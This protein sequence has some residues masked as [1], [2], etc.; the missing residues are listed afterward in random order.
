MAWLVLPCFASFVA[1]YREDDI[2][3]AAGSGNGR[4]PEG[5]SKS[6]L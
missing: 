3:F 1:V 2:G 6:R 5:E 4:N